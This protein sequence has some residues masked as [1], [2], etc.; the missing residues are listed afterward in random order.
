M[1]RLRG[2]LSGFGCY[3]SKRGRMRLRHCQRKAEGHG[4]GL[5]LLRL[6]VPKSVTRT[7]KSSI[8]PVEWGAPG[9]G[10]M[11][12]L[13]PARRLSLVPP[14]THDAWMQ[15]AT[16]TAMLCA[17]VRSWNKACEYRTSRPFGSPLYWTSSSLFVVTDTRIASASCLD[18][19]QYFRLR[20]WRSVSGLD[21]D[22]S[23]EE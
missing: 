3:R 20:N 22:Q 1:W 9:L 16:T 2:Q 17:S 6:E 11:T 12:V 23:E 21:P 13:G 14:G 8:R 15:G 5:R 4:T 7:Q 10:H 19:I 18:P